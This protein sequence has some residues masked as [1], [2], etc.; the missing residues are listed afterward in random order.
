MTKTVKPTRRYSSSRRREAAEVTRRVVLD[1]AKKLFERDGYVATSIQAIAKEA[2]VAAKTIY[3]IFG[4]KVGLLR[5]V[6]ANRLAPGEEQIPVLD[7]SWYGQ[8][9]H[10]DDPRRK[11][12]LVVEHSVSV[13]SR[14]AALLE[15]IFRAS[16]DDEVRALWN[17]I[18]AKLH[19]VAVGVVKQLSAARALR[20]GVSTR[21]AA[22]VLWALNHPTLW[23]LL[24]VRRGW[25]A[26]DYAV[27]LERALAAELT[28]SR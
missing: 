11:L 28:A 14:S 5:A 2:D 24:V 10:Q 16:A 23:Q 7:R 8:V 22:D 27:W 19:H 9:L 1:A 12:R 25:T 20:R 21:Q 26:R 18:D 13:K 6:W 4:G 15:V 3:L 17:E